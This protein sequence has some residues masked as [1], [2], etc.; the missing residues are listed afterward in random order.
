MRRQR[1]PYWRPGH[2]FTEPWAAVSE[3]N[4]GHVV[5]PCGRN[6]E[7]AMR[8]VERWRLLTEQG[9]PVD[10]HRVVVGAAVVNPQGVITDSWG[11]VP[12]PGGAPRWSTLRRTLVDATCMR[13]KTP[14][15]PGCWV[16]PELEGCGVCLPA[17]EVDDPRVWPADPPSPNRPPPPPPKPLAV[18]SS[19][20]PRR[21]SRPARFG[22]GGR[23]ALSHQ[24]QTG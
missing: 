18:P 8:L 3:T 11:S 4:V 23:Q 21:P 16:A 13:C 7:H 15:W 9:L 22:A 17:L 12:V 2:S 24:S 6:R 14:R 20:K 1:S 19:M 5:I 10:A